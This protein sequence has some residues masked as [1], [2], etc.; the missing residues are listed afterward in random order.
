MAVTIDF[1]GSPIGVSFAVGSG[2]VAQVLNTS[3]TLPISLPRTGLTAD[4][5]TFIGLFADGST[6]WRITNAGGA[7][8]ATLSKLGESPTALSLPANSFTFVRA[9]TTGTYQL[10]IGGATF[11]KAAGTQPISLG[12]PPATP[13]ATTVSGFSTNDSH[14][15]IGSDFNDSLVGGLNA[16]TLIGGLGNDSLNGLNQNDLVDGGAGNDTLIGGGQNDTL[17]GGAGNDSLDGGVQTDTATFGAGNNTVNLTLTT[18]QNTGEGTDILINIEN[19]AGGD[20]NDS[21]TGN[22]F[23]NQLDGGNGNDTLTG[24][25]GADRFTYN[26][27]TEGIDTITDF[28][29]AQG[30]VLAFRA[31][32]FTGLNLG[33]TLI[34]N[35]VTGALSFNSTQLATLSTGLA[36]TAAQI[37]I[38]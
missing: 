18:G 21:L 14:N 8:S 31:S 4:N 37:V 13:P 26:A 10:T 36:L 5:L 9:G 27:T 16:D 7:D 30:D 29:I 19:L 6:V 28:T 34:Y 22:G 23:N 38:F 20:G 11:T 24:G 1:S 12:A 25:S 35:S 15:I 33:T 3:P 17:I 2:T 32:A